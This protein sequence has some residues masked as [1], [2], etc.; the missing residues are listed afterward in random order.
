MAD[1]AADTPL[2]VVTW[3]WTPSSSY[4]SSF[5]WAQVSVLA[6]MVRRH[7]PRPHRFCCIT[8]VP[9]AAVGV[10]RIPDPA[11]FADIASPHGR[12]N[13]SCYRRLALF[14]PFGA[15]LGTRLVS[16]DLDVVITGDL[17]P[18]WD[19]PE[20][21]VLLKDT[22]KRGGYN[23]SMLLLTPGCRPQVWDRFDAMASPQQAL[24][25]GRFGSDQGW[26]SYVL[27]DGEAV[28]TAADGVYSY[29]NELLP[30]GSLPPDA[31]MV[32]FHGANVDPWLP[33]M[34]R[35]E[36]IASAYS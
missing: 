34:R 13:P 14:G 5:S 4:R 29:R 28:W 8:N 10:E 22:G 17:R 32:V 35:I 18:L 19:R 7:Y 12:R 31:R 15:T 24:L 23:G 25:A 2:T 6:S 27:G 3:L 11:A 33:H 1:H 21:L 9:G 30:S 26:I 36:W 16:L 20:D